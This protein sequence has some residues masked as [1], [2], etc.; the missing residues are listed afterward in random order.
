MRSADEHQPEPSSARG[1][2]AVLRVFLLL[3]EAYP[4]R[5]WKAALEELARRQ[6]DVT[7]ASLH[8]RRELHT[9]AEQLGMA[10]VS[11]GVKNARGYPLAVAR[12]ARMLRRDKPQILH[13]SES[14]QA[15]LGGGASRLARSGIRIYHRHHLQIEGSY[16]L[17]TAIARKT[18]HMTMAVSQA[19]ADQAMREGTA[20]GRVRVAHNGVPEP[21]SVSSSEIAAIR[22]RLGIID[23]RPI[24]AMIGLLRPEKGHRIFLKAIAS[25]AGDRDLPPFAAVVI[26]SE[27][28]RVR[29]PASQRGWFA[30]ELTKQGKE[31]PGNTVHFFDFEPDVAPWFAAADLVVVP[32]L[33][34][35]FG[36]VAAEA[37]ASGTPVVAS[38]VGGLPELIVD[39]ETGVMVPAGQPDAL[40]GAIRTALMH[41]E[42]RRRQGAAAVVRFQER[43]TISAMV[44]G[45]LDVYREA[46]ETAST[47]SDGTNSKFW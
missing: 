34:E 43:F 2:K 16:R 26:G 27:P 46:A 30:E 11:L 20:P 23:A 15:A 17:Y 41:E 42:L 28:H 12:M 5:Y 22:E 45:W 37:M 47:F 38:N 8:G 10:T 29:N 21:R 7:F 18:S 36:L 1:N 33:T 3:E 31:I 19:V 24:V 39:G 4:T 9:V 44:A 6:V 25:L 14:I 13:L 32:S 35:T 40:A